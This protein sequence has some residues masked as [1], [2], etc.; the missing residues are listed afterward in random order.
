MR[1]ESL[2]RTY[3]D[4]IRGKCPR[5][6]SVRG[7]KS[8]LLRFI[9]SSVH[10]IL[11]FSFIFSLLNTK[12]TEITWSYFDCSI[13]VTTSSYCERRHFL[14]AALCFGVFL[15]MQGNNLN[16]SRA[17]ETVGNDIHCNRT[18]IVAKNKTILRH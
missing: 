13:S 17:S 2:E 8:K 12:L 5:R 9:S 10:T 15:L 7:I 1:E 11:T 14:M 3:K 16:N 4:V 18:D 6:W